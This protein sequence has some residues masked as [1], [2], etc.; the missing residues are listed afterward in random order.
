MGYKLKNVPVEKIDMPYGSK[1]IAALDV[2]GE[3]TVF[4]SIDPQELKMESRTVY[5]LTTGKPFN[6]KIV[7]KQYI[8]SFTVA[9]YGIVYHYYADGAWDVEKPLQAKVTTEITQD[10]P[11]TPEDMSASPQAVERAQ[12]PFSKR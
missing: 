9:N 4:A 12:S 10:P 5:R 6:D 3:P 2:N 11:I 8:G 7:E 1:I